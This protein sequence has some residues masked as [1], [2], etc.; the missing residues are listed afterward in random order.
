MD[1]RITADGRT[2]ALRFRRADN[3]TAD[4]QFDYEVLGR[5]IH[6][7]EE[8]M[9]RAYNQ[10]QTYLRGADPR[11]MYPVEA[12]QVTEVGGGYAIDGR[13]VITFAFTT[14]SRM[15]IAMDDAALR[16]LTRQLIDLQENSP[17]GDPPK[18]S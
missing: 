5:L 9:G 3:S 14:G 1:Y 2:I 17:R 8:A 10:Q 12:R 18:V 13:V 11:L 15:D 4:L 16:L 7:A 6:S